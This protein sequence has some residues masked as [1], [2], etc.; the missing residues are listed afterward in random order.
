[1]KNNTLYHMQLNLFRHVLPEDGL[2]ETET[3]SV[4]PIF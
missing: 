2:I 1:M 4:L 3:C